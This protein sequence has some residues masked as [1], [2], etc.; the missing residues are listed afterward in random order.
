MNE[1]E[2]SKKRFDDYITRRPGTIM[3][4]L[5]RRND[6][7]FHQ[8]PIPP[9]VRHPRRSNGGGGGGGGG[10]EFFPSVD[11]F[12]NRWLPMGLRR[13]LALVLVAVGALAGA[14]AAPQLGLGAGLAALLGGFAGLAVIPLLIL[15]VKLSLLAL[16]LGAVGLV[17]YVVYL[18]V[19]GA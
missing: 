18:L 13:V 10:G 3:G 8:D 7:G 4:D 1:T 19:T 15:T 12:F 17:C 6:E 9:R 2:W 14:G 5:A 16:S 11:R